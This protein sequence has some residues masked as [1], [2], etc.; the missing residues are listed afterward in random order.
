MQVKD[1]MERNCTD[2]NGLLIMPSITVSLDLISVA[3]V[4]GGA[5]LLGIGSEV[6]KDIYKHFRKRANHLYKN[7]KGD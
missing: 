4:I 2:N 3:T 5:T 7:G 1:G 6:G